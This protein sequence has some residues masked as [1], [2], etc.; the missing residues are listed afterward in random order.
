MKENVDSA[1][2]NSI[3]PIN[4]VLDKYVSVNKVNQYKL[5]LK[6]KN[7]DYFWYSK[8]NLYLKK[9]SKRFINKND[10][11]I[12]AVFLEIPFYINKKKQAHLLYN[13]L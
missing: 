5:R 13:K 6:K 10:P 1:T 7:L 11:Q 8:I 9:L 3:D 12:K 2:K 4:F